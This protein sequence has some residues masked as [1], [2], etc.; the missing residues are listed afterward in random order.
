MVQATSLVLRFALVLASM[1]PGGE[2]RCGEVS[3]RRHT[4]NPEST[5]SPCAAIDVNRRILQ[6]AA[7]AVKAHQPG[8][9][10]YSAAGTMAPKGPS[11]AYPMAVSVNHTL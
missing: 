11:A 8:P 6:I 7:E 1:P 2:V 9:D 5:Y 10:T 4:L 3:F